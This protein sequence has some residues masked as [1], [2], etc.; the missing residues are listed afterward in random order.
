M[1]KFLRHIIF[2]STVMALAP[3]CTKRIDI[4]LKSGDVKLVVEG[5]LFDSDSVSWVRLTQT[6]GYFSNEPSPPVN[7]A[8][9]SVADARHRWKLQESS[10]QPGYYFLRDTAFH[11]TPSDTFELNIR[12]QHPVGGYSQYQSRTSVPPLRI[13]IDSL[14]IE[15]APDFKKWMIRYYGQDFPGKD[16]YLF[17]SRVNGKIVTDSILQ[18]VVRKDVF[19]DGRYVSGAVVQVLREEVMKTGDYYTLMASNITKSYYNYLS[20]LQDE[21]AE[22][23]PLFSGPPANVAGNINHGALGFFTAFFTT[24]YRVRLEEIKNRR[25][26]TFPLRSE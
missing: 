10:V 20:A 1:R 13:H 11:L 17:N 7:G 14:G 23:N 6:A 25:N 24:R 22:K 9:V 4:P 3:S 8:A 21:V 16:F 12:L 18:K 26:R 2:L 15:F 19:F 5:Y